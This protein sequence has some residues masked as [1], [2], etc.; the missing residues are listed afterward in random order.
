MDS[1]CARGTSRG[2]LK[3]GTT[4]HGPRHKAKTVLATLANEAPRIDAN[5]D[6]HNHIAEATGVRLGLVR[7]IWRNEQPVASLYI[8]GLRIDYQ[9]P[10]IFARHRAILVHQVLAVLDLP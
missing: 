10:A 9:L 6:F 7:C 8:E 3:Q 5:I 4:F 1:Q 2:C